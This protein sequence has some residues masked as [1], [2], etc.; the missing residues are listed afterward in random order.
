MDPGYLYNITTFKNGNKQKEIYYARR[1]IGHKCRIKLGMRREHTF[2]TIE[3]T[4]DIGVIGRGKTMAE[5]FENTAYGMFS[6]IADLNRYTPTHTI[7]TEA[8]GDDDVNLLERFL[9]SLI[10]IIDGDCV[11]PLD[12]EITEM[13]P[14]KLTCKVYARPFG[15]DIEWLGPTIKA[16][17]YHQMA[18]E[19][20]G[21][22]WRTRVIFD[23]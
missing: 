20:Q 9:S 4:A 3:H 13:S 11:L 14:G 19:K 8:E 21:D 23:V 6:I 15:E 7:E 12:F 1:R 22:E 5:A 18:V 10:V 2:E 17:T 16:V